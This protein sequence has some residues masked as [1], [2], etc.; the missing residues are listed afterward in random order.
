MVG[1]LSSPKIGQPI[2]IR[3]MIKMCCLLTVWV[4]DFTALHSNT[5]QKSARHSTSLLEIIEGDVLCGVR[6]AGVLLSKCKSG[7]AT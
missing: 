5:H 6:D 4:N 1:M 2:R 3:Q 7:I